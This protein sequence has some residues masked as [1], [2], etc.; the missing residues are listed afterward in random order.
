MAHTERIGL[1]QVSVDGRVLTIAAV[2]PG[3]YRH[4][5]R[6]DVADLT[7]AW[8]RVAGGEIATTRKVVRRLEDQSGQRRC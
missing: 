6:A 1:G 7:E 8:T 3:A 5:T 2:D 4:F